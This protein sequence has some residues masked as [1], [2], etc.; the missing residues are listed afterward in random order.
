[1]KKFGLITV[2]LMVLGVSAFAQA[3]SGYF[4][5]L[6]GYQFSSNSADSGYVMSLDGGYFYNDNWGLHLGLNYNEGKFS[7]DNHDYWV[8]YPYT[9][10]GWDHGYKDSFYILEVG[11]EL[12]GN[13]GK[14]QLYW[15]VIN[16][17]HTFGAAN[18]GWTWGTAAG[19]RYPIND[20]VG[21]NVQGTYHRVNGM[22]Y[23]NNDY[24][25]GYGDLFDENFDCNL[26]DIRFGVI[27][28]F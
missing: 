21:L 25:L 16:V 6:P 20:K 1:M 23:D 3:G 8:M 11:P 15:Q 27:W 26:W 19:Y 12:A 7:Y 4:A 24:W 2:F 18:N 22:G 13:A 28:K 17:G 10:D 14:G 9:V 5:V